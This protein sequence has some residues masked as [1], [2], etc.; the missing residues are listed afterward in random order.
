MISQS[1]EIFGIH[2]DAGHVQFMDVTMNQLQQQVVVESFHD[3]T[4]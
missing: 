3:W 4:V 1:D 2:L